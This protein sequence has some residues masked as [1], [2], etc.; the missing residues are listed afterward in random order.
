MAPPIHTVS[1]LTN[2]P[3]LETHLLRHSYGNRRLRQQFERAPDDGHNNVRNML[4]SI[5]ATKQYI[6]R[7]IVATGWVFLFELTTG[8]F[9][10]I[11]HWCFK[12]PDNYSIPNF[13]YHVEYKW[14][15]NLTCGLCSLLYPDDGQRTTI[16]KNCTKAPLQ[17]SRLACL[18]IILKEETSQNNCTK[19]RG[20][21]AHKEFYVRAKLTVRHN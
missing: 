16:C 5:Y 4:S 2:R 19:K 21:P 7:F 1:S 13:V 11:N 15:L 17:K 10:W 8:V 18:N 9:S 3:R 20:I 14:A 12:L 6:L